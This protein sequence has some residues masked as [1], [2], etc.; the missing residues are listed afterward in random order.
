MD[1]R[2]IIGIVVTLP[3]SEEWADYE[4]ELDK[5]RNG[6]SEMNFKVSSFPKVK[7]G[8][9]CYIVHRGKVRGWMTITGLSSEAF[10]CTTTGRN[11]SGKFVKRSGPFHYL[12]SDF[13]MKGFQGYRYVRENDFPE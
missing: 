10:K 5:V 12:V 6:R 2:K 11:W 7:A 8:D 4:K 9:R 3:A 1:D 13:P